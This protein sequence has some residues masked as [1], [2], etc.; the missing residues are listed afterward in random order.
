MIGAKGE[1]EI[2]DAALIATVQ[3]IEHYEI[4]GYG[5]ARS[6]A[7]HLG[8]IEVAHL[9][10]QSLGEE[11]AADKVLTAIAEASVNLQAT[12]ERSNGSLSSQ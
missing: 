5:T 6:F 9:L 3:R 10:Q 12:R 1:P 4:A 8:L 2:K 7:Q 11:S